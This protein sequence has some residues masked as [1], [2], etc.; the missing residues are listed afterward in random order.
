MKKT[1]AVPYVD[2]ENEKLGFFGFCKQVMGFDTLA[3]ISSSYLIQILI[4]IIEWEIT[5]STHQP[6]AAAQYAEQLRNYSSQVKEHLDTLELTLTQLPDAA[7]L[8]AHL[9]TCKGS[10]MAQLNFIQASQGQNAATQ[11]LEICKKSLAEGHRSLGYNLYL[12]QAEILGICS[13]PPTHFIQ[14]RLVNDKPTL[15]SVPSPYVPDSRCPKVSITPPSIPDTPIIENSVEDLRT[16][17]DKLNSAKEAQVAF[18]T[19]LKSEG[20]QL[21]SLAQYTLQLSLPKVT[22]VTVLT[23]LVLDMVVMPIVIR[24][25]YLKGYTPQQTSE[26]LR[27]VPVVTGP[28]SQMLAFLLRG[29]LGL[30]IDS[31]Q[32]Q[33]DIKSGDQSAKDLYVTAGSALDGVQNAQQSTRKDVDLVN[34]FVDN[35]PSQVVAAVDEVQSQVNNELSGGVRALF[36]REVDTDLDRTLIPTYSVLFSCSTPINHSNT[37]FR[38]NCIQEINTLRFDVPFQGPKLAN[39]TACSNLNAPEDIRIEMPTAPTDPTTPASLGFDLHSTIGSA[40]G[41]ALAELGAMY[42]FPVIFGPLTF[43]VL[44]LFQ[45]ETAHSILGAKNGPLTVLRNVCSDAWQRARRFCC[46]THTP[47]V[48]PAPPSTVH[49]NLAFEPAPSDTHVIQ[50]QLDPDQSDLIRSE[51]TLP[52]VTDYLEAG[53]LIRALIKKAAE[54][55]AFI[56]IDNYKESAR[57]FEDPNGEIEFWISYLDYRYAMNTFSPMCNPLNTFMEFVENVAT[58]IVKLPPKSTTYLWLNYGTIIRDLALQTPEGR[59]KEGFTRLMN[60][61]SLPLNQ[62]HPG[63]KES[64]G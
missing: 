36:L 5:K 54:P 30:S 40:L 41:L 59:S 42:L 43:A 25:C 17:F 37:Q 49:R 7:K 8:Q 1:V 63:Y 50:I 64:G 27:W 23:R 53:D 52:T 22:G 58:G 61:D 32:Y 38:N 14:W 51:A 3:S 55:T 6:D 33:Q 34:R 16:A 4:T 39:M 20:S 47:T 19:T 62:P 21:F 31:S 28:V 29:P 11:Y 44:T 60:H 9:S 45:I 12:R 57:R 24:V 46:P 13:P 15:Y 35:Y 18:D 2:I 48:Q 26:L 56:Q 10:L